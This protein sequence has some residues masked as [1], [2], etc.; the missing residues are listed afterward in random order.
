MNVKMGLPRNLP[1][2]YTYYIIFVYVIPDLHICIR[3]NL[4]IKN[5]HFTVCHTSV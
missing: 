5:C 2:M 3:K 1:G 4:W